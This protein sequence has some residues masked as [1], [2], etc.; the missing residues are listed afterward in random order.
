M[1]YF[2]ENRGENVLIS[3]AKILK[4]PKKDSGARYCHEEK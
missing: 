4:A 3:F 1:L 2:S